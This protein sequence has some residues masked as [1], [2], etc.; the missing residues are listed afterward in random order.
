MNA[1]IDTFA[2]APMWAAFLAFVLAMLALDLFVFGGRKAHRVPVR[3]ALTWVIV[4]VTLALGFAA[5]IWW[6]LDNASGMGREI[7]IGRA[8]V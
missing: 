1:T 5:L 3:E 6:Y 7:E 4:W 2:T 8:H